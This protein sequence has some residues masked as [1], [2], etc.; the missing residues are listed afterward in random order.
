MCFACKV[1]PQT[2]SNT[3][4]TLSF[5]FAYLVWKVCFSWRWATFGVFCNWHNFLLFL[6]VYLILLASRPKVVVNFSDS[7]QKQ[8]P[9]VM[10]DSSLFVHFRTGRTPL[11]PSSNS[12]RFIHGWLNGNKRRSKGL[13]IGHS[14]LRQ[15]LPF[16]SPLT[17]FCWRGSDFLPFPAATR[18]SFFLGWWGRKVF[19]PFS[20]RFF[21]H[22]A[23]GCRSL[24]PLRTEWWHEE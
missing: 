16:P 3:L 18:G 6:R 22:H 21:L 24:L 7:R 17:L 12:L 1:A 13:R 14:A 19:L 9:N 2:A 4:Q 23:L 5:R 11:R 15:R 20:T 8:P 10:W